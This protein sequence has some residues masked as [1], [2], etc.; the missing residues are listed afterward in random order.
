M[1][2]ESKCILFNKIKPIK[3]NSDNIII[4]EIREKMLLEVRAN[5]KNEFLANI[6]E[7]PAA[8]IGLKIQ[9]EMSKT[10]HDTCNSLTRYK[11]VLRIVVINNANKYALNP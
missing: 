3:Y 8:A 11:I 7:I 5:N 2:I 10:M 9:L 1:L 6:A 4:D